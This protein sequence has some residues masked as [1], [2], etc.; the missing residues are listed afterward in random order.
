[1]KDYMKGV[2]GVHGAIQCNRH[3][4]LGNTYNVSEI[5]SNA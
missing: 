2:V 1:M 4:S 3:Q 5:S